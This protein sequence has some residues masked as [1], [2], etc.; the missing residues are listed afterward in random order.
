VRENRRIL[1][2]DTEHPIPEKRSKK[3]RWWLRILGILVVC[4]GAAILWLNG[5]GLRT[6]GP[7]LA[8]R[9][10]EQAGLDGEFSVEG[11]LAGGLS[12]SGFSVKGDGA[13]A[14][15]TVDRITPH[16]SLRGLLRGQFEGITVEGVHAD[17]RLAADEDQEEKAPLDL[18]ALVQALRG[19]RTQAIP[20]NLDI[21]DLTLNATR[22]GQPLISLGSSN[23]VHRAGAEVFEVD[24]GVLTDATGR[25]WNAQ[26]SSIVWKEDR[27]LLDQL[28]ALPGI[29][30]RD[31]VVE[32]PAEGGPSLAGQ[33]LLGGGVFDLASGSGFESAHLEMASGA[34]AFA[35][36]L[37]PFGI[38]S[39]V[40]GELIGLTLD[41]EGLQPDP[42]RVTG[43]AGLELREL[44]YGEWTLPE[45]AVEATLDESAATVSVRSLALG[46]TVTIDARL[47]INRTGEEFELVDGA[48]DFAVGSLPAI[49]A[50][51]AARF[52]GVALQAPVP[53][54]S[55]AGNFSLSFAENRPV[56]ASA[57]ARVE[58]AGA[59]E[60]SPI[61][62]SG[63][64]QP[65]SPLTGELA[66]NGLSATGSYD[67]ESTEYAGT[68]ELREFS[69]TSLTSWLAVGGVEVPGTV[70]A[71]GRWRGQ[72]NV[73][74]GVHSGDAELEDIRWERPEGQSVVGQGG[75][76]YAWPGNV[77]LRDVELQTGDQSVKLQAEMADEM[78]DLPRFSW[79]IGDEEVA[80]G[81]G[82]VPV[83][84]D[85]KAWRETL[86]N[87]LRPVELKLTSRQ[88]TMGLLQQW[89][90]ALETVD[91]AATGQVDVAVSGSFA[92]PAISAALELRD[93]RAPD[94]PALP[95]ADLSLQLNA[96][97]GRILL[98]GTITAPDF[99]PATLTATLPFRPSEWAEEPQSVL[100]EI[101]DA[102]LD[103]PRLEL[104]RFAALLPDA[105]AVSGTVTGHVHVTG[106]L[107]EPEILGHLQLSGGGLEFV[108]GDLPAIR[109]VGAKIEATRAGIH[110]RDLGA[111]IAGGT[112]AGNGSATLEGFKPDALDFHLRANHLPVLRNDLM[113]IRANADLRLRG[114]LEAAGLSGSI[115]LVD[116]LFFR[117]IEILPIGSPIASPSAADLP[118][119]DAPRDLT[120]W[121]P[122]AIADWTLN[123]VVRT[124]DPF[125]IRGNLGTGRADASIRVGGTFRNPAPDG[126]AVISDATAALPFSTLRVR[127]GALRFTPANGFDPTLEIRANAEPRPYRVD[128]Y[129][130]G[131]LS[132]PQLIMTSTPGLPESEIMALLATGTTTEGLEDPEAAATRAI[133]LLIEELRRGRFRFGKQLRPLLKVLDRV[134]FTLAEKDPYDSDAYSTA[135]ISLSDRWFLS[136]GMGEGGDTRMLAIWRFSFR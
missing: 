90:P 103:L 56:R 47:G 81:S 128:I 104:S 85:F 78:L 107:G 133:Q 87:D 132:D 20:L 112:L 64:W 84:D 108:D 63:S 80:S 38:E 18:E 92:E 13:L 42:R 70:A 127:R 113:I 116:S 95:P 12:I 44:A 41:L 89:I 88:L 117:D 114:T 126:S 17:L 109:Q 11:N 135:T 134:D 2:S 39:P 60:I 120:A 77:V 99:A 121:V 50:E 24:L 67:L 30:V 93:L 45:L 61:A 35:E 68:L 36:V 83:P 10:L 57:R 5:P 1:A 48:G 27:M 23:L 40:T 33:V 51:L 73:E 55:L 119:I 49:G 115:G 125:L 25:E 4:I 7:R 96:A 105:V 94:Q 22:D 59:E 52:E 102:Q 37:Q 129:V 69:N 14:S 75:I 136:A 9:F 122:E 53:A 71:G 8:Q 101:V 58:P 106:P 62:I 3:R 118:K 43:T 15:L 21:K 16:Y 130:Y 29:G 86:A 72:G 26:S 31:L 66:V 97:D 54:S 111:S 124:E 76:G 74:A 91:P 110:L 123:V 19:A 6:F 34:V 79:R 131:Q 100:E 28:D 65:D 46:S 82:R 32:L 98:N